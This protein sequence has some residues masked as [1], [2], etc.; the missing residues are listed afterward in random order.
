MQNDSPSPSKTVHSKII[1]EA[2]RETLAPLGAFQRGR[3][4]IWIDDRGWWIVNIEFQP[5]GFGKGSYLNVGAMWLWHEKDHFTFDF[6]NSDTGSRIAKFVPYVDDQQ[7]R[8]EVL[9]LASVAKAEAL[10]LRNQFASIHDAA[11]HLP[12]RARR[13]ENPWTE[14]DAAIALGYVGKT[15]RARMLFKEIERLKPSQEWER[16]VQEKARPFTETLDRPDDFQRIVR[17]TILKTRKLL[18]LPDRL[19]LDLDRPQLSSLS[20]W[21]FKFPWQ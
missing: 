11:R 15:S 6:G 8:A 16:L 21:R 7:F 18:K 14:L 12:N 10:R 2:A 17:E 9:K 1:A 3:S 5:S 20:R 19:D 4:R 13:D